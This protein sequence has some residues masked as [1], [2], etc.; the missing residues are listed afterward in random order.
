MV[1]VPL[2]LPIHVSDLFQLGPQLYDGE[3]DHPRVEA[4]GSSDGGLDGSGRVEAHDEVVALGV[5][6]LVLRGGFRQAKGAPVR[7]AADYAAG[8]QHLEASITGDSVAKN[9]S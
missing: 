6:S 5:S 8:T 7:V 4:E 2:D 1:A 3:P 9:Q